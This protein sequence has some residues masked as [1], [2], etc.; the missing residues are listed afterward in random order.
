MI[1]AQILRWARYHKPGIWPPLPL[2]Q[3]AGLE[4][5]IDAH[6]QCKG[7]M[8]PQPAWDKWYES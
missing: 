2:R 5:R 8:K 4:N 1:L 6:R 7:K 3:E